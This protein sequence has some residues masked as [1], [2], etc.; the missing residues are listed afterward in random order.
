MR[1]TIE[2]LAAPDGLL[3]LFGVF[4]HIV[5]IVSAVLFA[6]SIGSEY[7]YGTLKIMLTR[8]PRRLVLLF[9]KIAA[10]A[11]FLALAMLAAF[12]VMFG[13][14]NHLAG[15]KGID[16]SAWMT[17]EGASYWLGGLGRLWIAAVVQGVIGFTL[18]VAIR[19]PAPAVGIGIGYI[20][21]IEPLVISA[22]SDGVNWLPGPVLIALVKGGTAAL[23][24]ASAAA[25]V[26]AYTVILVS[27]AS[28]IFAR[29]DVL[30]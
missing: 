5:G 16:V 8:E 15:A 25:L 14:T 23:P 17:S 4:V 2:Q 12:L 6:Q 29:R 1:P 18:G 21:A 28:V 22:W 7:T 9:A 26:A 19:A 11:G 13:V 27:V 20:I 3:A 10:L 24:L 30:S